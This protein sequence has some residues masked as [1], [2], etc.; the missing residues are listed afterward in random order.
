MSTW[1]GPAEDLAAAIR[2]LGAEEYGPDV[3]CVCPH[4]REGHDAPWGCIHGDCNHWPMP[5][6]LALR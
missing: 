5:T 6:E 4:P 3:P 2:A 1:I